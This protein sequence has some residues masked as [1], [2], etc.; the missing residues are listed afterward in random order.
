MSA[1][2]ENQHRSFGRHLRAEGR[3]ERTVTVCGQ[4]IRFYGEWL[5]AQGRA[6]RLA[7]LT[8]RQEM[9]T[10]CTR[11][12]GLQRFCGWLVAEGEIAANPMAGLEP[13]NAHAGAGPRAD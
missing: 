8:D 12:K 1:R 6:A 2:L 5:V 10:V 9:S 4:A 13:P 7:Q 11:Y 3:S